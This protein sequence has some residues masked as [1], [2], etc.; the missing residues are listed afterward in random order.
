VTPICATQPAIAVTDL[1]PVHAPATQMELVAIADDAPWLCDALFQLRNLERSGQDFPGVGD[2][3]INPDASL[4]V[5]RLL[6]NL[7][8]GNFPTPSLDVFSGGGISLQWQMRP[9]EVKFSIFPSREIVFERYVRDEMLDD[10]ILNNI[11]GGTRLLA[12]LT[13][14]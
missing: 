13:Q 6:S 10:G 9:R 2:L 1:C 7:A 8:V 12:W 14:P 3:R 11:S 4:T 5:K